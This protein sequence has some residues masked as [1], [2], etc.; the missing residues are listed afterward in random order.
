[1]KLPAQL[2][3]AENLHQS[4]KNLKLS[5]RS[6]A[7]IRATHLRNQWHL[8][9]GHKNL[10]E[11][12]SHQRCS[13]SSLSILFPHFPTM[14]Q[15]MNWHS[16]VL[17]LGPLHWNRTGWVGDSDG[18]LLWLHAE[19]HTVR[20]QHTTDCFSVLWKHEGLNFLTSS[21]MPKECWRPALHQ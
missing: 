3:A 21:R 5:P 18:I 10:A 14:G 9:S 15:F 20:S 12:G 17:P 1:M 16:M 11:L 13:W 4:Q 6:V 8:P 2:A 19:E 7:Q